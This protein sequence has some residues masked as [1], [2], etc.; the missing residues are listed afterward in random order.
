M[1]DREL[2]FGHRAGRMRAIKRK[3]SY[4][5]LDGL[6]TVVDD[7]FNG[8]HMALELF[9]RFFSIGLHP[10]DLFRFLID[11]AM[12]RS[13]ESWEVRRLAALM[14]ESKALALSIENVA[15]HDYLFVALGLKAGSGARVPMRS[16]LLK[17]GYSTT[18]FIKFIPEFRRRIGKL[19]WIHKAMRPN[20]PAAGALREFIELSRRESKLSLARYVFEPEEVVERILERVKVT[21]GLVDIDPF[22]PKYARGKADRWIE[23]LPPYESAILEG[24]CKHSRI[25]WVA[26]NTSSEINSLVEYPLSTV[27]LVIKPPGSDLEFEIKRVGRRGSHPVSARYLEEDG[28][29]SPPP[30]R[31]DGLS[32][33]SFLRMESTAAFLIMSIYRRVHGEDSPTPAYIARSSVY[34]VPT[35]QGPRSIIDY[36]THESVYGNGFRRMR[37]DL[38]NVVAAFKNEYPVS[39]A[40][41]PGELGMTAYFLGY[42]APCQ[43]FI[44]GTSSFRL[45]RLTDYLSSGGAKRYF[46]KLGV[47]P[48]KRD[49]K[50]FADELLEEILGTYVPPAFKYDSYDQYL[51]AAFS[52]PENRAQ[53]DESFLD[54]MAAIGRFWGTLLGVRG[55]SSGESFVP[56]NVGIKS[57]WECG[58]W[59]VKVIL[60]D[61]DVLRMGPQKEKR[62]HAHTALSGMF[63]DEY[64]IMGKAFRMKAGQGLIESLGLIY[65]VSNRIAKQGMASFFERMEEGYRKTIAAMANDP[66]LQVFFNSD[67]VKRLPN[68]DLMVGS[69]LREKRKDG[70]EK[71]KARV[72]TLFLSKGYTAETITEHIEAIEKYSGLL[73]RY[74][75]LYSGDP[76]GPE[77]GTQRVSTSVAR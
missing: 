61:H 60:M 4:G 13:G 41:L 9:D 58:R 24:L 54:A 37:T 53:A 67:F 33:Q 3:A 21:R 71:W 22:Q 31:I 65:R 11:S 32:M 64:Y 30:H 72:R 50:R 70:V 63:T 55:Y 38:E 14:L 6:F 16:S 47:Q 57:V 17:E 40:D 51:T 27:A 68:W 59:K 49:S 28:T 1:N 45:D 73:G 29:V 20:P 8:D 5:I 42:L 36:F 2:V 77:P 34:E 76:Q 25:Y 12:G 48:T 23:E 18:S 66:G 56:R 19:I 74:A 39:I 7:A 44:S 46:R 35:P 10:V 62:F 69:Y 26:G 15:D 52:V 43:A 75:F